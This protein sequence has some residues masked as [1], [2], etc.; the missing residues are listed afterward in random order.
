MKQI[1]IFLL[2]PKIINNIYYNDFEINIYVNSNLY[3]LI[4]K[5]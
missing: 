5:K 1:Y 3:K 4:L 2:M